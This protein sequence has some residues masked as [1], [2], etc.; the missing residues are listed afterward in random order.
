M[1][2]IFL[3]LPRLMSWVR[4]PLPAPIIKEGY[5]K[6][7]FFCYSEWRDE[8]LRKSGSDKY[9]RRTEVRRRGRKPSEDAAATPIP[10]RRQTIY[11]L[12]T[13]SSPN[14]SLIFEI[15]FFATLLYRGKIFYHRFLYNDEKNMSQRKK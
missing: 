15:C 5:R 9:E 7:A 2:R 6:V 10:L 14:I 8:E 4:I 1:N 13:L 3:I 11:Y 12:K